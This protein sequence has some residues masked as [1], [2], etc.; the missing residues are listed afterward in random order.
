MLGELLKNVHAGNAKLLYFCGEFALVPET[1]RVTSNAFADNTSIPIRYTP[2]GANLSPDLAWGNLPAGTQTLVL[3][4][5]DPDAPLPRPFVLGIVYN[6]APDGCLSEGALPTSDRS[7]PQS[8]PGNLRLGK[9]TFGKAIF[10]GPGPIPDHG[11]HQYYFQLFA[12]DR[13][14]TFAMPPRRSEIL[15]AINGH[16]LAK[17]FLVGLYERRSGQ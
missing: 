10:R 8:L 1:L 17:G 2:F 13:S 11:P 16:V 5:E 12:L 7:A 4:V 14:L 9:N 3:V 15:T 6:L